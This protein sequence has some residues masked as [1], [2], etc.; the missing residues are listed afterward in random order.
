VNGGYDSKP[1]RFDAAEAIDGWISIPFHRLW[2]LNP[3][4]H[5]AGYGQYC[6]AGT[7]V[8]ALNVLAGADP[9]AATPKP[10]GRPIEFPPDGSA[11]KLRSGEGEWPDPLAACPGYSPPMGLA[12]TLQ[13]GALAAAKLSA[14]SI[15]LAGDAG[16]AIEAC[17]FDAGTYVNPDP[18][19][20]SRVRDTLRDFGA[21]VVVPRA[22]LRPGTYTVSITA[23]GRQYTWSFS[24]TG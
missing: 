12:I 24:V 21:V 23:S 10:R 2:I 19:Q 11:L 5:R 18:E 1:R 7:C 9:V 6:E 14:Y 4:L 17:G 22:P 13:L 15:K 8:G 16:A 20:Q 3:D